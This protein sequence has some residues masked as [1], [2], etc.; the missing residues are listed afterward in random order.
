[1]GLFW[2]KEQSGLKIVPISVEADIDAPANGF[3]LQGAP[4]SAA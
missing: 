3:H 2:V 1:M 4:W